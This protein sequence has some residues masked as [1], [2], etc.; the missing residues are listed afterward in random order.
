MLPLQAQNCETGEGNIFN[1]T[2]ILHESIITPLQSDESFL[3][4]GDFGCVGESTGT[5]VNATATPITIWADDPLSDNK[6][7]LSPGESFEIFLKTPSGTIPL[8]M[9][10]DAIY[11]IR[12]ASMDTVLSPVIDQLRVDI[13]VLGVKADS[14]KSVVDIQF[15][16]ADS[17]QGLVDNFPGTVA[18]LQANL[19]AANT[20]ISAFEL[21]MG[22]A[23]V[24]LQTLVGEVRAI[25]LRIQ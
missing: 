14:L 9:E 10:T 4:I 24:E 19:A 18:T 16:R 1:A 21:V 11:V 22:Q 2:L 8:P 15:A 6:N 12:S 3:A 23:E 5:S 13:N 25:I 17:L 20:T 7:G